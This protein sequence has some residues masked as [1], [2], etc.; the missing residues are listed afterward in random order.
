[1]LMV[2]FAVE[3][4]F[5]ELWIKVFTELGMVNLLELSTKTLPSE[6]TSFWRKE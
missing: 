3:F 2:F 4:S 5:W 1:M 6:S